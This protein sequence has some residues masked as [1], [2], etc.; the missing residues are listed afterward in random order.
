[1]S[2]LFVVSD[3]TARNTRIVDNHGRAIMASEI[4]MKCKTDGEFEAQVV[5]VSACDVTCERVRFAVAVP[6]RL[7]VQD[8]AKI[9]FADGSEWTPE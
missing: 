1:M 2:K 8:V 9:V 3:G 7:G 6:G 4:T 5:M